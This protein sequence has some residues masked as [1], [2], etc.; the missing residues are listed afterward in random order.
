MGSKTRAQRSLTRALALTLGV[1]AVTL[2]GTSMRA[3]AVTVAPPVVTFQSA[4]ARR[5]TYLEGDAALTLATSSTTVTEGTPAS[6]IVSA[7][8]KIVNAMDGAKEVLAATVPIGDEGRTTVTYDATTWTLSVRSENY[9]SDEVES[10]STTSILNTLKTLT[11]VHNGENIAMTPRGVTAIVTDASGRMSAPALATIKM[12]RT[13]AA[14]VLDLNGPRDGQTYSVVLTEKERMIGVRLTD[15]EYA[16]GDDDDVVLA[17]AAI[18]NVDVGSLPDGAAE[19]I[20]ADTTGTSIASAWDSTQKRLLLSNYDSVTNYCKVIG[21]I[22]YHNEGSVEQVTGS[23]YEGGGDQVSNNLKFTAGIRAFNFTL[24]DSSG[25]SVTATANVDVQE[26]SRVGD[27]LYDELITDPLFCNNNGKR[28]KNSAVCSC[29]II[30]PAVE[31]EY[32]GDACE[33]HVCSERGTYDRPTQTCDCIDSFSGSNC[34]IE[35]NAH[36]TYN[37]STNVCECNVGFTGRDC[38][39]VCGACSAETGTCSLTATSEASWNAATKEYTLKEPQCTCSLGYSGSSCTQECPCATEPLA[40]QGTCGADASGEGICIC[41]PGYTGADCTI[42]CTVECGTYGECYPPPELAAGIKDKLMEIYTDTTIGDQSAREDAALAYQENNITT[43]CKCLAGA[44]GKLVR[45]G[46]T[47]NLPCPDCGFGECTEN[48]TCSCFPGYTGADC[49]QACNG[50]GAV[51]YLTSEEVAT[52]TDRF[53]NA[54]STGLFNTTDVHEY[55]SPDGREIAFCNCEDGWTGDYCEVQ[56][57]TCSAFGTCVFNGTHGNCVCSPGFTG[58]D[59]SI[60]CVPCV[61]GTCGPTGACVCNAGYSGNDCNIECGDDIYLSRG[62]R[63]LNGALDGLGLLGTTVTCECNEG[64]TGPMC[65][66]KCPYSY[67][68]ANGVCVMKDANDADFGDPWMTEVVCK[69]GWTGLPQVN[70]LADGSVSRGRDCNKACDACAFGTCQDDGECV[71][72]YGYIWQPATRSTADVGRTAAVTPY[73]WWTGGSNGVFESADIGGTSSLFY[74][75]AYHT[76]AI[77][78]P[79]SMNGEYVNATCAPGFSMVAGTGQPWTNVDPNGVG[80]YGCSGTLVADGTCQ[81]GEYLVAMPYVEKRVDGSIIRDPTALKSHTEWGIIAGA[82]CAPDNST[83][84]PQMPITG[85]YCVCDALSVGRSEF[86]SSQSLTSKVYDE[87]WQG[88]AGSTCDIPCAPCSGNGVCNSTTGTCDCADGWTGYRCLTPCEPCVHG[89]CQYDGSCLCDGTRR[90]RDHSFALRLDRDPH[91]A[92]NGELASGEYIPPYYMSAIQVEDYVWGVDSVCADRPDCASRTIDSKLPFRPN[93][94]YFRYGVTTAADAVGAATRTALEAQLLQYQND[95]VNIPESMRA[96]DICSKLD[97][98]NDATTGECMASLAST[99]NCGDDW[100]AANP[101]DCDDALK[102]HFLR[103]RKEAIGAT[104]VDLKIATESS[105][106]ERWY[107][108][109]KDERQRLMNVFLAGM[110]DATSGEYVTTRTTG[111]DRTMIWII[112]TLIHGVNSGLTG[113]YTGTTCS[114]ACDACDPDHGTCQLNGKCECETGWY[115]ERC[116]KSCNCFKEYATNEDGSVSEVIKTTAHGV[117]IRSWGFCKRDGTCVCGTDDGGV[118]YSGEDCF[119]PCAPCHNGACQADSTCLCNKG[120]LGTTCDI[121]NFTECLPCNYDHGAC[122]TDGTCKCDVGWTGLSCDV[123]CNPCVNGYCQMDGSCACQ[124]GWSFVDCS[125]PEASSFIVKSEFTEGPEGWTVYN[126]SC[127]GELAE[128][129][130]SGNVYDPF[131][132]NSEQLMR[133]ECNFAFAGGDSGLLWEGISGYLH[134]TDKLTDDSTNGLAY[135]RAPE[136][137]TGDLLSKNAYGASITYS[138][139]MVESAANSAANAGTAHVEAHQTSAYDIILMGGRPRYNR[140]VPVWGSR[141]QVYNWSR[142]NFPELGLNQQLSRAQTIAIVEQYLNTPQVF[143]GYKI[144]SD[145]KGYPPTSCS[146]ARCGLNF[147]VDLLESA[148]WKNLE[149]VLSG[150]KWSND[151]AVHY[152]DGTVYTTRTS[153]NPYDPFSGLTAATLNL[154]ADI[155]IVT[156]T[157]GRSDGGTVLQQSSGREIARDRLDFD[158]Y[159]EVYEAVV[160]NRLSRTGNPATFSD[161][162]WCL[163]SLTEILVRADYYVQEA[164]DPSATVVGESIRF[165]SFGIGTFVDVN[166]EE[167]RQISLFNYYR[168]YK[169][170]YS[171]AYLDELYESMRPSVCKGKWYLTGDPDASLGDACKQ[172]P[173]QLRVTCAGIFDT[174]TTELGDYCVIKCPGYDAAAGTTCSG[175]GTCGLNDANVPTCTCNEGYTASTTGCASSGAR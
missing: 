124:D 101:W 58:A 68:A 114:I 46:A 54:T 13:N 131:A 77:K 78:H 136:K 7:S 59:C 33:T 111:A 71:C 144:D 119:V 52:V 120:W 4:V 49:S 145:Q 174:T 116:D 89:T 43:L 53:P 146:A 6:A 11:Y 38:S 56:C 168:Q 135:L 24:T 100:E 129:I 132:I 61:H 85:G 113:A 31:S 99:T 110:Y 173:A 97:Y 167:Q 81:G 21:T 88:W 160:A 118:Q 103:M 153:G 36:G 83:T 8:V 175:F 95:I 62:T 106:Q 42:G 26:S 157:T 141:D 165:D 134:L 70:R 108:N 142:T 74:D 1:V 34:G 51:R 115:G 41:N 148:G 50:N 139:Y 82:V 109:S 127:S 94:T 69:P 75:A 156:D 143:L 16:C 133:G 163:A 117:Q 93:E 20:S 80:G 154:A 66:Y 105:D 35:C 152:M 150:F 37:S 128:S 171:V 48:A 40:Q 29:T 17:S 44:D 72:D 130:L 170:D 47:C 149:P 140:E 57:A 155:P 15:V 23:Q 162:A 5:V 73:P 55:T 98:K 9:A 22:R 39:V 67:N 161:L 166:A 147:K 10:Y 122:L 25:N 172:D 123:Q 112:N 90:L 28:G 164:V 45:A 126:N 121:R 2:C 158:V 87:Y 125:R 151:P 159:P 60:T 65:N 19:Y 79:C 14:P 102:A 76:C 32:S 86:P 107:T 27:A 91:Y 30:P 138:L 18:A 84:G 137:F 169:N 104:R 92:T 96:D 12:S 3:S 63:N 64:F